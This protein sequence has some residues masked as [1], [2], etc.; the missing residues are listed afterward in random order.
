MRELS[1]E[2]TP[3]G[4]TESTRT[5]PTSRAWGLSNAQANSASANNS[6]NRS[7]TAGSGTSRP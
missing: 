6:S 3:G 4:I 5:G 2:G 1:G 7:R